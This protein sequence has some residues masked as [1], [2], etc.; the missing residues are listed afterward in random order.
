MMEDRIEKGRAEEELIRIRKALDHAGDAILITDKNVKALYLNKAF[1]ELFGHTLDSLNRAGIGSI[2]LV[3]TYEMN[4][5]KCIQAGQCWTHEIQMISKQGNYFPAHLRA[6]AIICDNKLE[7]VG[8]LFI[9]SD[10]TGR[11]QLEAHL[12]QAQKLESIGLLASGIAHEINTPTQYIGDNLRFLKD[13][14]TDLLGL[15]HKY[16]LLFN[17]LRK[18]SV[19]SEL[20]SEIDKA[21]QQADIT[22]LMEEIPKAIEQ[23]LHG[24]DRVSGIVRAMKNFSHPGKG[25]KTP[26]DINDAINNTITISRNEW[27][28]VSEIVTDFDK[29]LPL[30]PCLPGEFNQVILNLIINAKD[31]I[32]E[33]AQNGKGIIHISTKQKG[34]TAEIRV[35]DS[36][37]GIPENIRH[38]IFDP[39]FTTKEVGKGSGQGLAI[40]HDVIVKKHKGTITFET[41]AGTGTT[42]IIRLPIKGDTKLDFG[43]APMY[44][45]AEPI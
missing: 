14:F 37:N 34:E 3:R 7:T 1:S 43:E 23:S 26:I 39:F 44:S 19:V 25:G 2:F 8:I 31:A 40:S 30:V 4:V 5:L 15:L 18:G 45:R 12:N 41:E 38:K 13:S 24:V 9:I 35:S 36:G 17:T 29:T 10:M 6:S 22:Y 32:A 28:Y 27:K 20:L 42:F 11:K 16:V 33:K 21:S